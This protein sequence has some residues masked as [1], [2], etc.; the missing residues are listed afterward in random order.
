MRFSRSLIVIAALSS[1]GAAVLVP[2][3]VVQDAGDVKWRQ[4]LHTDVSR[5][6][7]ER[8]PGD[9][10][11]GA[12][13]IGFRVSDEVQGG[14]IICG[15]DQPALG[16][17]VGLNTP[18]AFINAPYGDLR[19]EFTLADGSTRTV[20]P[21]GGSGTAMLFQSPDDVPVAS[22]RQVALYVND[23]AEWTQ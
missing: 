12:S 4:L 8:S 14:A 21:A 19:V 3:A 18:N 1:M 22:L 9:G 11:P 16:V 7:A 17:F 15:L 10:A 20:K 5:Y 2:G 6:A 23:T 13:G